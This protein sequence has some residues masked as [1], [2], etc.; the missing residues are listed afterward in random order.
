[1]NIISERL[2]LLPTITLKSG[3]HSSFEDGACAMEIASWLIGDKWSDAPPCVCPVLGAFM[4]SW[5]DGIADDD[6]RTRLLKPLIPRLINTRSTPEIEQRRAAMAAD[7][8]I[9]VYTPAWLRLAKL[10]KQA[11]ALAGLPEIADLA[12]CPSVMPTLT[13]AGQD[14]AAAWAAAWDAARAA[15][16]AA[17]RD[18]LS[19]TTSE[20]QQSALALVERMIELTEAA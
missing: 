20:L 2:A 5:N 4:R 1:M 17:A 12:Q 8:L 9:R 6:T 14:A 19:K 10:D 3:G 18:A 13:A 15:A 16:R 11:D 7:W